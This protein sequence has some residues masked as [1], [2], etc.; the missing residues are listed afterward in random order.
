MEVVGSG[1]F[2]ASPFL[3]II[4]EFKF[5]LFQDQNMYVYY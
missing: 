3:E 4:F 2:T 5:I 1:R